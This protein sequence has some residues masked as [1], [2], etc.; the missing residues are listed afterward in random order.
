M[1]SYNT[2]KSTQT[3]FLTNDKIPTP[4]PNNTLRVYFQNI[5]GVQ[6]NI[7]WNKW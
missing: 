5:N 4:K 7:N 1:N 3:L 2:Q 6:L